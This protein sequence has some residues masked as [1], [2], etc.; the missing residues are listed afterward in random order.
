MQLGED[1][2]VNILPFITAQEKMALRCISS[3]YTINADMDVRK[4]L[5]AKLISLKLFEYVSTISESSNGL[6]LDLLSI[7]NENREK[8]GL[9]TFESLSSCVFVAYYTILCEMFKAQSHFFRPTSISNIYF[10][11]TKKDSIK[12]CSFGSNCLAGE[13]IFWCAPLDNSVCFETIFCQKHFTSYREPLN[14]CNSYGSR[15]LSS[16]ICSKF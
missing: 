12:K 7:I 4:I 10:F 14:F 3:N 2:V 16:D 13:F 8:C 1:I 6:E 15:K 9:N 11:K 5:Q